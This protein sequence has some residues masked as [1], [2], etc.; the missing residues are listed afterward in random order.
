MG[1]S[2]QVRYQGER[3][4]EVLHGDRALLF[5]PWKF[6]IVGPRALLD[7]LATRGLL[8]VLGAVDNQVFWELL[9]QL[10]ED[11]RYRPQDRPFTAA[12]LPE[13]FGDVYLALDRLPIGASIDLAE[14]GTLRQPPP[15]AESGSPPDHTFSTFR[16]VRI[17]RGATFPGVPASHTA[18]Q[19][20]TMVEEVA[21]WFLTLI[22]A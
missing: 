4:L 9:A 12:N 19:F 14:V 22:P 1:T 10:L 11:P 13:I 20:S 7:L 3:A 5:P 17:S 2:R 21:P 6:D 15:G 8:C 18:K 16:Y